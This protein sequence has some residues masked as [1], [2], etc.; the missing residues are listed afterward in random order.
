M[1]LRSYGFTLIELMTVI[2][3]IAILAM[4]ATPSYLDRN[5]R[6][7]ISE[8]LPLADIAKTP[9]SI[10]WAATKSLPADNASAGLPA[11]DKIVNS[12][13][14]STTVEEGAI[15]VTFGNNANQL[16]KGKI[17]TIRPAV[18]E[19]APIVPITWVCGQ[20][21]APVNMTIKG[22]N[23]TN[24]PANYLPFKCR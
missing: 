14:S 2:A 11:A 10:T 18:I 4:M 16:L 1:A 9:I 21:A 8:A 17:L 3:I 5:I 6:N 19:D 23:K 13:I 12:Y 22:N 20:S 7:Q 24:I 15:H